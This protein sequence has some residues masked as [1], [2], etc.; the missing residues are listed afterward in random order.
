[1]RGKITVDTLPSALG[2]LRVIEVAQLA[3]GPF[4]GK[5]LADLGAEVIKVEPP[6]SGDVARRRGPFPDDRPDPDASGSFLYFNTNKLGVTAD[7]TTGEGRALLRELLANADL[8]IHDLQP[9]QAAAWHLDYASLALHCPRLVVTTITPFGTTG[10]WADFKGDGMHAA[11][12]GG[13]AYLLPAGAEWL[14][15]P[16]VKPGGLV[17]DCDAGVFAATGSLAAI[18]HQRATGKGQHVDCSKQE[19]VLNLC[20]AILGK[21]TAYG[22]VESRGTRRR[23]L[24]NNVRCRD[25]YIEFM[26]LNDPLWERIGAMMGGPAWCSAPDYQTT[27]SRSRHIDEVNDRVEEW[28]AEHTRAEIYA[29][30]RAIR[31]PVGRVATADEIFTSPHLSDRGFFAEVEHPAT[32]VTTYPGAPYRLSE[33]PWRVKRPAPRLGEHN[34]L[35]FGERLGH[36]S[37]ELVHLRQLGVI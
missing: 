23:R 22:V 11:H 1:M 31:A 26:A 4:C 25:G 10:P 2:G 34:A 21:F 9:E 8:L 33:T 24:G 32:G 7:V 27:A 6:G 28:A 3:A 13:E 35:V 29:R 18:Y 20:R 30:A 17:T 16:P 37:Q 12:A 19:A 14:D 36:S 15:R 5:L